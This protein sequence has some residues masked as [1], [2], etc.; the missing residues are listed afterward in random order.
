MNIASEHYPTQQHSFD[1]WRCFPLWMGNETSSHD[2]FSGWTPTC[3]W[4]A[5]AVWKKL[6]VSIRLSFKTGFTDSFERRKIL[7][8]PGFLLY[9][10]QSCWYPCGFLAWWINSPTFWVDPSM[11]GPW[12]NPYQ[13]ID[14]S[15]WTHLKATLTKNQAPLSH[16]NTILATSY[17]VGLFVDQRSPPTC[18]L[19]QS[20]LSAAPRCCG[21]HGAGQTPG[22]WTALFQT[23]SV[24]VERSH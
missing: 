14:Q 23:L 4:R 7:E 8:I 3:W 19:Q 9:T 10:S 16:T 1:S 17:S 13:H 5:A 6:Q 2:L 15:I 18:E 20:L 22:S 12:K 11:I 24:D 21:R